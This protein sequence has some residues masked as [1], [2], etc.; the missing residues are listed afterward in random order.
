MNREIVRRAR[1][2]HRQACA[3]LRCRQRCSELL[4]VCARAR[5][6]HA[7]AGSLC[8]RSAGFG[9]CHSCSALGFASRGDAGRRAGVA[10]RSGRAVSSAARC[11]KCMRAA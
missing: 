4:G 2:A 10:H 7:Q 11:C 9:C 3:L 6:R 5:E 8:A 1:H